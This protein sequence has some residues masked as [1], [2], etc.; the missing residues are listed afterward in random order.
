MYRAAMVTIADAQLLDELSARGLHATSYQLKRWRGQGLLTAPVRANEGRGRGRPSM[1]YPPGSADAA[2]SIL[3]AVQANV[4]LRQAGLALFAR[5]VP[6]RHN[7]VRASFVDLL[8]EI[9]ALLTGLALDGDRDDA[10][11]RFGEKTRLRAR[12]SSTVR[13]W[14]QRLS[15]RGARSDSRMV[16]AMA[17][18]AIAIFAGDDQPQE[19][20][21]QAMGTALGLPKDL[22][23]EFA[24]TLSVV[25]FPAL[26]ELAD[27]VD[28]AELIAARELMFRI[29]D[30]GRRF[31]V[32]DVATH[33]HTYAPGFAQ[34]DTSSDLNLGVAIFAVAALMRNLPDLEDDL[35]ALLMPLK[36][37][38]ALYKKFM[39]IITIDGDR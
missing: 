30:F 5:R 13:A 23:D 1:A 7:I 19:E 32:V 33:M 37:V 26:R 36:K 15:T 16:E 25:S 28:E 11:D 22:C 35:N 8:D 6:V 31:H 27:E 17:A 3:R 2:E 34:I 39:Q 12:R 29:L 10:I 20:A 21:K 38:E 14:S 18:L 4:P 24:A 9:D